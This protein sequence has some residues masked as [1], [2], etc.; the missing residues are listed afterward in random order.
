MKVG[1]HLGFRGFDSEKIYGNFNSREG[2]LVGGLGGTYYVM[3]ICRHHPMA[4]ILERLSLIH[5]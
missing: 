5:I 4:L 1:L 2:G 3:R